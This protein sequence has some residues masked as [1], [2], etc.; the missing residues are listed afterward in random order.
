MPINEL[1]TAI[2][3][4][5]TGHFII[6]A[7]MMIWGYRDLRERLDAMNKR[8]DTMATQAQVSMKLTP[9]RIPW[10]PPWRPRLR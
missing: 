2:I 6:L 8:Q 4:N 5:E 3:A 1:L 10:W 9:G 7:A